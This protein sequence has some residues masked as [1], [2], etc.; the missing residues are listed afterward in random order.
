MCLK[1][2]TGQFELLKANPL[3]EKLKNT[4]G[5]KKIIKQHIPQKTVTR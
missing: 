3:L 5:Y 2:R 4:P 1:Y